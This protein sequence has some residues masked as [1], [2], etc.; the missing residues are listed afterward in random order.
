MKYIGLAHLHLPLQANQA[1]VVD[2]VENQARAV[3]MFLQALV[4]VASLALL[5]SL[6]NRVVSEEDLD[7]A[8]GT[9]PSPR[10][11]KM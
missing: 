2:M 11:Q 10:I 9:S 7:I 1:R 6:E 4:R 5:E 8:C 3:D